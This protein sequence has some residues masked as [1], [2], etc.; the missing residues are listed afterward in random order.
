M[1]LPL[2]LKKID[3][4][5]LRQA[6]AA[7][8]SG[9]IVVYPTDTIY[10]VGCR[11]DD[12][13]AIDRVKRLKKRDR[14][15]PLI[16]IVS[17]LSMAKK[18]CFISRQQENDLK[19]IWSGSRPTSV[20][21]RQRHRLSDGLAPKQETLAVRL[22]KND[23]LRKMVRM[24]GVPLVST[25]FNISGQ[26]VRNEVSFLATE[27]ARVGRPDLILDGGFLPSRASRIIDLT[28]RQPVIIRA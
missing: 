21:L 17:S 3:R 7:F 27:K 10:G 25:S 11:A 16:I 13:A 1:Y 23:F 2:S 9:K 6:A 24:V 15:K 18:Y 4:D 19:K 14:K 26:P 5:V 20:I 8:K 28:G 22:P 12:A